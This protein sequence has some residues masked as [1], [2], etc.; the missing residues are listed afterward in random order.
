MVK[1]VNDLV[2]AKAA[3]FAVI[4]FSARWCGPCKMMAPVIAQIA[5]EYD[6]KIKVGKINVDDEP[7]LAQNYNV[8]SI[9]MLAIFKNGEIVEKSVG[10]VSKVK[11]QELIDKVLA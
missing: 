1:K 2:E 3:K 9:P 10:A 5:G 6:G 4:D 11:L 7:D 8:M